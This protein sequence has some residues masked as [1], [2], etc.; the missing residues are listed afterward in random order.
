MKFLETYENHIEES[1]NEELIN[2]LIDLFN[3]QLNEGRISDWFVYA[4]KV[5]NLQEKANLLRL[6]AA[7]QE[8]DQRRQIERAFSEGKKPNIE[9]MWAL[10][11]TKLDALEDN[12]KEY[13][14]EALEIAGSNEYLRKVQRISRLK[15]QLRV[16]NERVKIAEGEER[17]ELMRQNTEKMGIIA[18]DTKEVNIKMKE[19]EK[20]IKELEK[21]RLEDIEKGFEAEE[22]KKYRELEKKRLENIQQGFSKEK[23]VATYQVAKK[24][25]DTRKQNAVIGP[26]GRDL[27]GKNTR[28]RKFFSR[29]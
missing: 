10:L 7:R 18:S 20:A 25:E 12:A 21:K 29:W 1:F 16:N 11:Q 8:I 9:R 4:P 6:K 15:G 17:K 13:E 27:T 2:T 22:E 3:N 24:A 14:A 23:H 19:D 5:K 26:G 28:R